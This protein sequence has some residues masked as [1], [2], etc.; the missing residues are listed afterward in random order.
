M[1]SKISISSD[2]ATWE[3]DSSLFTYLS[4]LQ[5][6]WKS[7]ELCP[8]SHNRLGISLCTYDLEAASESTKPFIYN[9]KYKKG[10]N[11]AKTKFVVVGRSIKHI[12]ICRRLAEHLAPAAPERSKVFKRSNML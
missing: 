4:N 5:E 2:T 7:L 1:W 11:Y 9:K 8:I 3:K 12:S 6:P 10:L